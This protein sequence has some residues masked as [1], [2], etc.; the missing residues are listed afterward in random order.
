MSAK[1]A[2]KTPQ[3]PAKATKATKTSKR[4]YFAQIDAATRRQMGRIGGLTTAARTDPYEMTRA[5]R[6][7]LAASWL[8][9]ADP[10]GVLP[11]AERERRAEALRKAHYARMSLARW[12]KL[13]TLSQTA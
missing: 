2:K 13:N 7:G 1:N 10:D 5:M 11:V 9:K 8:R 4:G 3:Q 6:D 12:G